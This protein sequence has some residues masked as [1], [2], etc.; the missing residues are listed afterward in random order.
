MTGGVGDTE[1]LTDG[2]TET[3]INGLTQLPGLRV[4]ARSVVFRYKSK[5]VD[6]QQVGRDLERARRRHRPRHRARR[7]AGHSG[8][9]DERRRRLAVVGQSVQPAGVRPARRAGRDRRRD[10]RQA[11]AAAERR[12][13]RSARRGATP[14]TPWPIRCTCRA[15][16]T[17]TRARST[18]TRRR[19][20]TSS[21]RSRRIRSTRWPT[22]GSPTRICCSDRT[23][24]RRSPRRKAAARTGARARSEPGRSARRARPHQAAGS[25]GTGRPPSA[26]SRRASR[27]T[28]SSALAHNQ[29]AMYLATLGRVDDAIAEVRR[30]QELDPLSPIVNSDLGWYL[31]YGGPAADAIAQFRKTLE[32]DAQLRVGASRPRHRAQ[33]GAAS[34]TTRSPS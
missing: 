25:T 22:P 31:L 11:A 17:G 12:G 14:T 23:G 27:S 6:P 10:S 3:L 13:R 24:S 21:R 7:S 5:D 18:A 2:I 16:I 29:F 32:F 26:S 4:T 9:A 20:S 15:A 1:Y 28:Q 8:R 30:A 34:T 33:P 19:S